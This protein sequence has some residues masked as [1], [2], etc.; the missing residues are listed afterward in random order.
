MPSKTRRLSWTSGLSRT[1]PQSWKS[2]LQTGPPGGEPA[3]RTR[4][5]PATC[6]WAATA[7]AARRRRTSAPA[8]RWFA[9]VGTVVACRV[10]HRHVT[11][12]QLGGRGWQESGFPVPSQPTCRLNTGS[13]WYCACASSPAAEGQDKGNGV[14]AGRYTAE[15]LHDTA[16]SSMVQHSAEQQ[17]LL[18]GQDGVHHAV[19]VC[20]RDAAAHA[21]PVQPG[22]RH[23]GS[24]GGGLP[25]A[26]ISRCNLPA[27]LP[28][29]L[30]SRSAQPASVD[31]PHVRA[32]L[33][34][35]LS[36]HRGILHLGH[37][38][39][40][41]AGWGSGEGTAT[42]TAKMTTQEQHSHVRSTSAQQAQQQRHSPGAT[43]GR[44]RCS[45]ARRWPPAAAAPAP[46]LPPWR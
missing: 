43:P 44:W 33:L 4:P 6:C 17:S 3:A 29:W 23:D 25:A 36:Q 19:R 42:G 8:L 12:A 24:L 45:R 1:A 27:A 26:C 14:T 16:Q 5:G 37:Q 9:G 21:V 35:L 20:Q 15:P 13:I 30:H 7:Q 18:T 11:Q 2:W 40:S 32:V 38:G 46:C 10:C 28:P 31:Q 41:V 34:Q 39:T 22:K